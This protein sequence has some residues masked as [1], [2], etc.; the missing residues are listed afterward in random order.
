[1]KISWLPGTSGVL[2]PFG[3]IKGLYFNEDSEPDDF[4]FDFMEDM[5]KILEK[6]DIE[7]LDV[8]FKNREEYYKAMNMLREFNTENVKVSFTS[9]EGNYDMIIEQE[10][11][12]EEPI[13]DEESVVIVE[14]DID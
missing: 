12:D 6:E 7:Y 11:M 9:R 5:K 1:M 8:N 14:P 2:S 13:I 4:M 10:D 3:K